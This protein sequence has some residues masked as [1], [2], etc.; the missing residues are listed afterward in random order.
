MPSAGFEPATPATKRPQTYALDRAVTEVGLHADKLQHFTEERYV[1]VSVPRAGLC[2]VLLA[3]VVVA[4]FLLVLHPPVN[5][6]RKLPGPFTTWQYPT[7]HRT[8][9]RFSNM[10]VL[11]LDPVTGFHAAL[12]VVLVRVVY[13]VTPF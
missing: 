11:T 2:T 4:T 7:L 3:V 1:S 10:Y 13:W 8:P 6:I 12:P 5:S 9:L